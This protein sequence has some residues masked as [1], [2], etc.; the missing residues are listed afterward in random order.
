MVCRYLNFIARHPLSVLQKNKIA[1]EME[2]KTT[3]FVLLYNMA[4][5]SYMLYAIC[6]THLMQE[7]NDIALTL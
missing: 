6:Y 1:S 3:H 5:N 2:L 7:K 4:I